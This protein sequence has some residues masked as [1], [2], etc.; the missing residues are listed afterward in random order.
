[1]YRLD[2]GK[3][4]LLEGRR[5]RLRRH[6]TDDRG[7]AVRNDIEVGRLELGFDLVGE[8]VVELLERGN[9][10]LQSRARL[11]VSSVLI[12]RPWL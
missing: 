8:G 3:A 5:G 9:E 4:E 1:M 6:C 11:E 7:Q 10:F 2:H 12:R